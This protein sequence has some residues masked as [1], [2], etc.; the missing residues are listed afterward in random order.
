MLSAPAMAQDGTARHEHESSAVHVLTGR[1]IIVTADYVD[2]LD[3]IGGQSV[4]TGDDLVRD[5]RGQIGDTLTNQPGVS[6]TSFTP[7]ASRPVLRGFQGERIRVLTDGLGSLDVSNTST[8]HGVTIDPLTAERIEVLRGPAVLLFGSQAIGGAVNVIDRRIPRNVPENGFHI[9]AQAGYGTAADDASFGAAADFTLAPSIVAHIDGSYRHSKDLRVGG[10][11]LSPALRAEQLEIAEEEFEEGHIEEAEEAQE[12]AELHGR[13]PNSGVETYTLGGGLALINDGGSLGFSFGYYDSDYGVPSRPG[14]EHHHDE[15]GE[16]HDEDH[17]DE[18]EEEGHDHGDVPVSIGMRQWRADVR[19]QINT[20]GGFLD[21]VRM[22][23]GYADYKHTEFEGDEVGTVFRSDALEGRL[24]LVQADRDGWRGVT[25]VQAFVRDFEAIG[26]EAFVPPNKTSQTGVFTL[27]EFELGMLG[28][29]LAARYEHTDVS[30]NAVKAEIEHDA[31]TVAV[32]RSFDAFSG[33]I[34]LSYDV[35]PY[36]R[37]G[38]TGSRAARA[39][40]AEELFSNGP[41]IATQAYEVGNPDFKAEKSWGLE[42]YIRGEAGPLRFSLSGYAQWFDDYIYEVA[43]GA[44]EDELPVY[45]FLQA[46]ARYF[47]LEGEVEAR[48]LDTEALGLTGKLVADYVDAKIT[49]G[50]G[51]VPRIP[52][53]RLRGGL[54]AD[55]GAVGGGVEVEHV[56][57]QDDVASFETATDSFTLVNASL[58][59]HPLGAEDETVIVLSANNIFDVDARRHASFTKDFVPLA[60]RDVRISARL[61]F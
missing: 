43:T 1:D 53:L 28:L 7:G 22:R 14:A 36:V 61:S 20:S 58:R 38:V 42:G 16:D 13:V 26:A 12:L 49:G 59:W 54:S 33:A 31:P 56:F 18:H 34:G 30:S 51:N 60:G 6:A 25:G 29:E 55:A 3:V 2:R 45:Q 10:Y 35:A 47:G 8:D 24:E 5:L 48:L 44:E 23:L 21:S 46:D 9:D 41:H 15:E 40:S 17:E 37:I 4:V 52:P 19:A 32:D 11:V 39:P 50:G 57:K 27:Q